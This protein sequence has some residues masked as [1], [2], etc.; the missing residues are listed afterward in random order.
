MGYEVHPSGPPDPDFLNLPGVGIGYIIDFYSPLLPP[1]GAADRRRVEY[2]PGRSLWVQPRADVV[3]RRPGVVFIHGGGWAGGTPSWHFRHVHELAAKGY[4]AA[5]IQYRLTG[6]AAWPAQIDDVRAA[7]GW[8]KAHA[9]ELGL[10]ADRIAVSGGSA[11]GHLA[12]MAALTGDAPAQAAV[13]WYP[14]TDLRSIIRTA[15]GLAEAL[16]PNADDDALLSAS[17]LGNVHAG[18]PPI[19]TF[20]ADLDALTTV[21]DIEAFHHALDAHGVPNELVVFKDRDHGFDFHPLDWTPCFERMCEFL[22][23]ALKE[24]HPDAR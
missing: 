4:V 11:G 5:T 21:A 13:L 9:D 24:L 1:P 23:T 12:A 17:P 20:A 8:L 3:E 7:L 18:A 16:V 2:Q 10:D 15:P 22:E 6:E 19:L 14:A